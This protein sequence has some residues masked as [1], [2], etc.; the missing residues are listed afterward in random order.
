MADQLLQQPLTPGTLDNFSIDIH[1]SLTSLY[2]QGL[3]NQ[4]QFNIINDVITQHGITGGALWNDI[5]EG[6]MENYILSTVQ[7]TAATSKQKS[8][9]TITTTTMYRLEAI[10]TLGALLEAGL[11]D[12]GPNNA[13]RQARIIDKINVLRAEKNKER[14]AK[15][16]N[17]DKKAIAPPSTSLT[18]YTGEM[19]DALAFQQ[20]THTEFALRGL[21]HLLRFEATVGQPIIKPSIIEN[22]YG[23]AYLM[24]QNATG[25]MQTITR[26]AQLANAGTVNFID[27]YR[28]IT[29]TEEIVGVAHLREQRVLREQQILKLKNI[30]I[31]EGETGNAFA[32]RIDNDVETIILLGGQFNEDA[33]IDAVQ[34]GVSDN[35]D[36]KDATSLL[37]A[38]S[39]N[40]NYSEIVQ[41]IHNA[42]IRAIAKKEAENEEALK[43]QKIRTKVEEEYKTKFNEVKSNNNNNHKNKN[44]PNNNNNNNNNLSPTKKIKKGTL[45]IEEQS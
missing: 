36:F 44:N 13:G 19:K 11:E 37:N 5:E 45:S 25:Q 40:M 10:I 14:K 12:L 42:G 6:T 20:S 21:G 41:V 43:I 2:T 35:A 4:Q 34:K 18:P 15:E 31:N 23:L 27:I 24:T 29:F 7:M 1:P 8:L 9:P 33:K 22:T 28:K 17:R 39:Y 38:T 16:A 26:A 3:L 30:N 32:A